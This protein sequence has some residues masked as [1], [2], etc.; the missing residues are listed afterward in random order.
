MTV[1]LQKDIKRIQEQELEDDISP[2]N[3][4]DNI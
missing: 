1:K 3:H 4:I 2:K